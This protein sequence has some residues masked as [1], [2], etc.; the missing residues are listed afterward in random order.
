MKKYSDIAKQ[1]KAEELKLRYMMSDHSEELMRGKRPRMWARMLAD[2]HYPD[3]EL[4]E[5][6]VARFSLNRLDA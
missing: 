2:L 3:E 5:D 4:I 6:M 1:L